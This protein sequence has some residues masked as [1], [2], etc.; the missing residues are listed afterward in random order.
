ME[1]DVDQP[2]LLTLAHLATELSLLKRDRED[3]KK[4]LNHFDININNQN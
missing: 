1:E 2:L 4:T 3:V